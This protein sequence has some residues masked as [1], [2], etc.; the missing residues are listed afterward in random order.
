MEG[1]EA[2]SANSNVSRVSTAISKVIA[3]IESI[4][5]VKQE[6]ESA[7]AEF[8]SRKDIFSILPTGFF[9]KLYLL[10]D[11]FG[12]EE[13]FCY[14]DWLKEF[15]SQGEYSRP[16]KVFDHDGLTRIGY[17]SYHKEIYRS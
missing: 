2:T 11:S 9:Q 3:E 1:S 4:T 10:N 13:V 15:V 17:S 16:L 14:N 5:A 7:L 6:R 8:L 12:D